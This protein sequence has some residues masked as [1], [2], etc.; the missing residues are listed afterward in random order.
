MNFLSRDVIFVFPRDK[1]AMEDFVHSFMNPEIRY[2]LEIPNNIIAAVNVEI[3]GANC[4]GLDSF[5]MKYES[6]AIIPFMDFVNTLTKISDF[7]GIDLRFDEPK[8]LN[9][10]TIASALLRQYAGHLNSSHNIL[11]K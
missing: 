3:E 10:P 8:K 4:H 1:A 11:C 6:E 5:I 9:I 7:Q 2:P